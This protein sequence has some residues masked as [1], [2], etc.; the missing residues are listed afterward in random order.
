MTN[1]NSLPRR[2]SEFIRYHYKS[3]I[4][5]SLPRRPTEYN[6]VTVRA[7]RLFDSVI[8]YQS[9]HPNGS[10]YESALVA[11]L[12]EW[13]EVGDDVVIV[14]GGWGVTAV[15]AANQVGP[16]GHV[17]VYEGSKE[18][19]DRIH[20]T[21]ELNDVQDR[22]TVHH[23]IVGEER[24]IRGRKESADRLS[25]SGLPACDILE[26][27]CEGTEREIVQAL[28]KR[29]SLPE[30]ILVETHGN[31]GAPP[32]EIADLLESLGYRVLGRE[33]AESQLREACLRN[34]IYVLTAS[35]K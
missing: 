6:G 2:I 34:D 27:D 32:D 15:V 33:I 11:G 3:D 28:E 26:L 35:R 31:L 16:E 4:R 10:Q 22:V 7:A 24:R 29:E 17:D 9:G 30:T 13:A 5:P 18:F 25:P 14:G 12:R 23:A 20:E 19:A 1:S 21:L 8:P